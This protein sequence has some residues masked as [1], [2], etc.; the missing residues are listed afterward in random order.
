MAR[1]RRPRQEKL[2]SP[3]PEG[4]LT[5]LARVAHWHDVGLNR[6]DLAAPYLTELEKMDARHP[7]L[8][9]RNALLY[10]QQGDT[11]GERD[12]L[13]RMLDA[14]QK[15]EEKIAILMMLADVPGTPPTDAL[16]FFERAYGYDP[17]NLAVLAAIEKNGET[18]EKFGQVEWA[19]REQITHARSNTAR[20]ATHLRAAAFYERRMLKRELAAKDLEM[21]LAL[22][23]R[24][25]EALTGLE[26]CYRALQSWPDLARTFER[27]AD[28]A[29]DGPQRVALLMLAAE[30][31]ELKTQDSRS[32]VKCLK[33]VLG[34]DAGNKKALELSAKLSTKIEDWPDVVKYR[35]RLAELEPTPRARAA[36]Y[37]QLADVL[38]GPASDEREAARYYQL[39][40]DTDPKNPSAWEALTK[41][42]RISGDTRKLAR[43]LEQR[44]EHTASPRIRAQVLVELAETKRGLGD[45]AGTAAAYEM[46]ILADKT[47]EDAAAFMLDRYVRESKWKAAAPLCELLV[48]AA[49]RDRETTQLIGRLRL[50]TRIAASQGD[51]NRAVS[52][53]ISA[54]DARPDDAGSRGDLLDLCLQLRATPEKFEKALGPV[55]RIAMR[56]TELPGGE[57]GKLGQVLLLFGPGRRSGIGVRARAHSRSAKSRCND[58]PR[59]RLRCARRLAWRM[60]LQS[61]PRAVRAGWRRALQATLRGRR[62]LGAQSARAADGTRGLGEGARAKATRPAAPSFADEALWRAGAVGPPHRDALWSRRDSRDARRA[63]KKPIFMRPSACRKNR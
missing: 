9:R 11:R 46:A 20:V 32:A 37:T 56:V 55:E 28:V 49:V 57:L 16:R 62:N 7:L 23:P 15:A 35:N 31:Y 25:Q 1:H 41:A 51:V 63:R 53:A 12:A 60:R 47:N 58:D 54:Y 14:A 10:R 2:K 30:V 36:Q 61:V 29:Q 24:N 33:R 34:V 8:L 45:E 59:R 26:R 52:A 50:A 4:R 13:E 39:A 17:K 40:V 42:A 21:V 22:D 18:Q 38:A 5:L 48:N 3:V 43:A 44:A 27:R 19:L 6:R